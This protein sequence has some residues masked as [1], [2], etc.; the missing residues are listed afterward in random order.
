MVISPKPL[1]LFVF[2]LICASISAITATINTDWIT[3]RTKALFTLWYYWLISSYLSFAQ[4]NR[5]TL[6]NHNA[7]HVVLTLLLFGL[8]VS[9]TLWLIFKKKTIVMSVVI[10]A[11]ISIIPFT[12]S[13]AFSNPWKSVARVVIASVLHYLVGIRDA[14]V[15]NKNRY[16]SGNTTNDN[17]SSYTRKE[18][19]D[20][21]GSFGAI[22]G[23]WTDDRDAEDL[24]I[25]IKT[26]DDNGSNKSSKTHK[27]TVGDADMI[28]GIGLSIEY[29]RVLVIE[30]YLFFGR[31]DISIV[32]CVIHMMVSSYGVLRTII[33]KS[34]EGIK[35]TS[36][37]SSSSSSSGSSR[38][39]SRRSYSSSSLSSSSHHSSSSSS[40]RKDKEREKDKD[41]EKHHHKKKRD[42]SPG[43]DKR[44]SG[45]SRSRTSVDEAKVSATALTSTSSTSP[46][47]LPHNTGT[48]TTTTAMSL[49]KDVH[50]TR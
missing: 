14:T 6:Y 20:V 2:M 34:S 25:D 21:S 26:M 35:S 1:I 3:V 31:F 8:S 47:I 10:C 44:S 22:D 15:V 16:Y 29:T 12:D 7:L 19:E 38:D 17:V 11:S 45:L 30:S 5:Y 46:T 18:S 4:D 9:T 40:K 36:R 50:A 41:K 27:S 48:T 23:T 49:H 24:V 33:A 39:K 42:A 32:L 13:V 28:G 43:E 37:S